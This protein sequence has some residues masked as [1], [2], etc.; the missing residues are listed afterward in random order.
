MVQI[1]EIAGSK[2]TSQF[3]FHAN[4][5]IDGEGALVNE[6]GE[7]HPINLVTSPWS[8]R[9]KNTSTVTKEINPSR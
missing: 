6:A 8:N 3:I 5:I 4:Y 7:K 1:Y 9:T 2:T